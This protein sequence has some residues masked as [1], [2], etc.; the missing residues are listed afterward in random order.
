MKAKFLLAAS[1]A[2]LLI[3]Q[4]AMAKDI[5]IH[6]GHL[7]DGESKT[8]RAQVSILIHDDRITAVQNGFVTPAGAEVIDLSNATVLPGL[9]D[10]HDHIT[11]NFDGG[12]P[13][14]EAVTRTDFDDAFLS[15]N[16]AR[17][18]LM[19]GFTTIRDVGARPEVVIALKKAAPP[20]DIGG[21]RMFAPGP[22]LGPTGGHSDPSNGFDPELN[23]KG[24]GDWIVDS[25]EAARHAVRKLHQMGADL[26]KIM[27]SGGVLSVA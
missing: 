21:P 18:T 1:A 16:N 11:S 5:V 19:A 12:N 22:P 27:P 2:A 9:I 20:G 24:W 15:V 14:A 13:V 23:H 6:A 3:A 26:I 7:L 4:Q 10:C 8:E 25:P 17:N